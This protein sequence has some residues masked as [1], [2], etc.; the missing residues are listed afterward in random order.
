MQIKEL[1]IQ[2][3]ESKR[4]QYEM[5]KLALKYDKSESTDVRPNEA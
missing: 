3:P 2:I 5:L 4:L 1:Q